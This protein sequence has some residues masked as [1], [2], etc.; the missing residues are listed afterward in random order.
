MPR[1]KYL[2]IFL[3]LIILTGFLACKPDLAAARTFQQGLTEAGKAYG[4]S[5]ITLE[6][7]IASLVKALLSLIGVV[8]V[9][10]IIYGGFLYLTSGG[11][12][13]KIKKAK[14]TLKNSLIGLLI[15]LSGYSVTYFIATQLESP[16]TSAGPPPFNPACEDSTKPE[17]YNALRCCEYRFQKNGSL[18]NYC[19][20]TYS[21]FC[22][23]HTAG[24]LPQI[25]PLSSCPL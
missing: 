23:D 10:L 20:S 4:S 24:C 12:E 14:S 8:F 19:C 1:K 5:N 25:T 9:A 7:Y 21:Q 15:V 2:F 11:A 18:D 16:G 22:A 17:T 6:A 13:D 3:A